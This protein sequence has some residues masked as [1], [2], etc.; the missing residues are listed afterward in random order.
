M[1]LTT[2]LLASAHE[3]D[4]ERIARSRRLQSLVETCRRRLLGVL[5]IGPAC[6]PC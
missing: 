6:E 5:P 4:V 1:N 3:A 2:E